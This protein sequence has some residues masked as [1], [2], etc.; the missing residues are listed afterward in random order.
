[1]WPFES[2]KLVSKKKTSKSVK[3]VFYMKDNTIINLKECK[4]SLFS[5]ERNGKLYK[6]L[7]DPVSDH[8]IL[9]HP[10]FNLN[11]NTWAKIDDVTSIPVDTIAKVTIVYGP[12]ETFEYETWE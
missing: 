8:G 3:A 11:N 7:I 5:Y 4:P 9:Y 10:P 6:F 1:M 2:E 12:E